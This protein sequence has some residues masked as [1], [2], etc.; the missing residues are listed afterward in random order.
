MKKAI[1]YAFILIGILLVDFYSKDMVSHSMRE[2]ESISILGNFMKFT[3]I[4]NYGTTFGLFKDSVPYITISIVKSIFIFILFVLLLKLP[5]IFKRTTYQ[6][7]SGLCIIFI[8]GGSLGN[9]IDRLHDKRV[10]DFIDIGIA[11]H[12]WF[13]FNLA[14]VFQVIGG[15]MIFFFMI[16]DLR[17]IDIMKKSSNQLKE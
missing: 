2:N 3:L 14:D 5:K 6:F 7:I 11:G 16:W 17:M 8:I 10:T 9:V 12:R 13:V 1:I 15:L 4:Y